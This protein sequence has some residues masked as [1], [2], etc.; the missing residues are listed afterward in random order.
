MK[1]TEE[2]KGILASLQ[3]R[4][5]RNQDSEQEKT[6]LARYRRSIEEISIYGLS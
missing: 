2:G 4:A 3:K 6:L 5:Q 1:K